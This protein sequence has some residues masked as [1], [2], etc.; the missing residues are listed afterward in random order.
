MTITASIAKGYT[1]VCKMYPVHS[2]QGKLR[3]LMQATEPINRAI[4]DMGTMGKVMFSWNDPKGDPERDSVWLE[5]INIVGLKDTH[6]SF[7]YV[8]ANGIKCYTALTNNG[9]AEAY[10][11]ENARLIW[12]KL[13]ENNTDSTV[14]QI[15]KDPFD[16]PN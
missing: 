11:M 1:T 4:I 13:L 8:N 2:P 7:M 15:R 10:S 6:L 9:L 14:I 16:D 5:Y 12:A 3:Q